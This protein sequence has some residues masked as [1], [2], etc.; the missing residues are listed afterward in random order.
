MNFFQVRL[1]HRLLVLDKAGFVS[2]IRRH[3]LEAVE[4]EGRAFDIAL[5]AIFRDPTQYS[6]K[7]CDSPRSAALVEADFLMEQF[8]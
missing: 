2:L 8:M 4:H 5:Q 1:Q 7:D 3:C 6:L